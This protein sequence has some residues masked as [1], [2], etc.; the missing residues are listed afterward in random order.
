MKKF[1]V[2]DRHLMT[3]TLVSSANG[4][5]GFNWTPGLLEKVQYGWVAECNGKYRAEIPVM[6]TEETD[7]TVIGEFA[8]LAEAMKAVE[9]MQGLAVPV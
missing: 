1:W 5:Y 4:S 7:M 6:P 9:E 8:T 3:F 2:V